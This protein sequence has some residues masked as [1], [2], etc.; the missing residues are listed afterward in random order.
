MCDGKTT[1]RTTRF[2]THYYITVKESSYV[3]DEKEYPFK[4][5]FGKTWFW[6]P[7]KNVIGTIG[8]SHGSVS[9]REREKD[10]TRV[11]RVPDK[12]SCQM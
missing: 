7:T 8:A 9:E 4:K 5:Y 6:V 11:R 1:T 10:D 2:L 12:L 3:K